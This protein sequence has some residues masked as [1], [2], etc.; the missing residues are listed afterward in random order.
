V[1]AALAEQARGVTATKVKV[2]VGRR[3]TAR[4]GIQAAHARADAP[5]DVRTRTA[6]AVA[7]LIDAFG[8]RTSVRPKL[9]EREP[10]VQ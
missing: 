9:A 8:I 5:Q 3:G 10:R 7:P 6:E 2:G 4:V 1:V